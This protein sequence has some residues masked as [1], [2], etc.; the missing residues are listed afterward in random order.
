M[1]LYQILASSKHRKIK[2]KYTQIINLKYQLHR[3]MINF[4]YS[5]SDIQHYFDYIIKKH[6]TVTDNPPIRIYVNKIENR[7]TFSNF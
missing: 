1:L 2:K 5:V 6:E 3:G 4:H 7:T